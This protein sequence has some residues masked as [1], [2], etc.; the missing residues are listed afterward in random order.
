MNPIVQAIREQRVLGILRSAD[1][2]TA[3]ASGELLMRAGIRTVEVSL[4]TPSALDAVAQLRELL[5]PGCY[6]GVGTVTTPEH[7]RAA[8]AAGAQFVVSPNTDARVIEISVELGL[9]SIPGSGTASE[10]LR[11]RSAG[12]DLVKLF[13]ASTWSPGAVK[14]LLTALPDLPLVPTGGIELGEAVSWIRS[15]A[16]AVGLGGALLRG[17]PEQS[18]T[19]IT[20]L[21]TQLADEP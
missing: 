2:R 8:A 20:R 16:V 7:V 18:T 11:A 21:L 1:A 6:L 5:P 10:A 17:E 15:G 19:R 4:T 14:D 13:P 12:A 9:T 3:V